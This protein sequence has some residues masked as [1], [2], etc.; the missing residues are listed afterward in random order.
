MLD[1]PTNAAKE[2]RETGPGLQQNFAID[3]KENSHPERLA[4]QENSATRKQMVAGSGE[5]TTVQQPC[6]TQTSD[7]GGSPIAMHTDQDQLR[8]GVHTQDEVDGNNDES[9]TDST[10]EHRTTRLEEEDDHE[11]AAERPNNVRI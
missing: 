8:N 7:G 6:D 4:G 1:Q 3:G 11:T 9:R 5:K 10:S 2:M